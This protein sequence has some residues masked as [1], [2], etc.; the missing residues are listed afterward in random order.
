MGKV[1]SESGHE[2]NIPGLNEPEHEQLQPGTEVRKLIGIVSGK[3]GVGKSLVTSL[4]A[5]KAS[6]SGL[7]TAILDSDITGPSIPRAFGLASFVGG[8]DGVLYPATSEGGIEVMSLNLLMQNGTDPVIWRGPII[9]NMVKQFWTEIFWGEVDVMFIDMP[10]GTGDVALTI[11]QSLP[12]DGLVIVTSPQELVGMIVEKAVN[13]AHRMEIPVLGIVENMSYVECPD[14]GKQI[15]VFGESHLDDIA[16]RH[17]IEN[18]ACL[19]MDPEVA[20][21]CD[22]GAIES[23]ERDWLDEFFAKLM[24]E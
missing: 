2:Y 19:P 15:K 4:L 22:T 10:P 1:V 21:A 12:L 16:K 14:C 9:S 17:G 5:T 24:Q 6:R 3:G 8:A 11:F 7:S 18:T 13:M 20:R 23:I